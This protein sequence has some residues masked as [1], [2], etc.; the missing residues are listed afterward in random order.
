MSNEESII[1]KSACAC[2]A[3]WTCF[4]DLSDEPPT[5]IVYV[6]ENSCDCGAVWLCLC[7]LSDE[8]PYIA[9]LAESACGAVWTCFCELSD[10]VPTPIVGLLQNR[11]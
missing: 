1:V 3:V 7:D 10:E 11:V 5:P 2:G 6:A 9:Y 8:V 4:C